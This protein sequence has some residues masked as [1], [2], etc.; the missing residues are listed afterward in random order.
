MGFY[1][2]R[3]ARRGNRGGEG[4]GKTERIRKRGKYL[5]FRANKAK[6]S[7]IIKAVK[8]EDGQREL[9]EFRKKEG[10]V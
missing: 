2:K 8:S 5:S 10:K 3:K 7:E 9:N 1:Y 4:Q 6:Q